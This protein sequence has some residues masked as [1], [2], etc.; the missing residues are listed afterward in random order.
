MDYYTKCYIPSLNYEIEV[1]SITFGDYL[2]LNN[3]I[4]NS[5]YEK[6]NDMFEEICQKININQHDLNNLDKFALI[7]HLKNFFFNKILTLSAKDD[8]GNSVTYDIVLTS[9]IEKIKTYKFES[10]TLPKKLYY[11]DANVILKETGNSIN[12][13][14]K[15]INQNKILMFSVPEMIVGIPKVYFNCFDN[16]LFYFSKLLMS[17]NII[18]L[19]KKITFLK[20][21][22]NFSL[23]EIY[24]MNPKELEIFIKLNN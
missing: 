17:T 10:F 15:H 7:L 4:E 2:K 22:M 12:D 11:K 6:V 9:I 13:I 21:K 20:R 16:T 1:N 18:N 3:Y 8:E 23:Y 5:N 19:Y 14:K 24:D